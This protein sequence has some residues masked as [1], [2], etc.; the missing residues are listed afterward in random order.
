M[1]EDLVNLTPTSLKTI[2]KVELWQKWRPLLP[3]KDRLVTYSKSPDDIMKSIKNRNRE[4]DWCVKYV[5]TTI[6]NLAECSNELRV[7]C[8]NMLKSDCMF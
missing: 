2:K 4:K 6:S 8:N 5:T 7:V 1:E 3:E